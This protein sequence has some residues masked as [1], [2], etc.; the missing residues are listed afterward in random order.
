MKREAPSTNTVPRLAR[1]TLGYS[2]EQDRVRLDGV[3]VDGKPL[4][5]WLTARLLN[6][7]VPHLVERQ[8]DMQFSSQSPGSA[9]TADVAS[10]AEEANNVHCTPDSP[11]ILVASVDVSTREGQFLLVFKDGDEAQRGIFVMPLTALPQWNRGLQQCFE[12]AGWAQSVFQ[13]HGLSG[14]AGQGTVTIH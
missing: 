10:V 5:L 1:I 11:E 12:Q 4:T 2:L 14:P 6:R 9:V 7:L 13:S 3:D 8:A